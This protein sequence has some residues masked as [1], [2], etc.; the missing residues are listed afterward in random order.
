MD[1]REAFRELKSIKG[2]GDKVAN[3]I[4]LFGLHHVDAFPVDTHI[5]QILDSRYPNG[6]DTGRFKGYAGIVQQYMF[7]Y[8]LNDRIL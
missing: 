6:F 7:N 8:K 1:N 2:I 3:C 5:K 4:C